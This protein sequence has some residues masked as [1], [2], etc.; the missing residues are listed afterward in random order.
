MH[1]V[2]NARPTRDYIECFVSAGNHLQGVLR[3]C[4]IVYRWLKAEPPLGPCLEHLSFILMIMSGS[5]IETVE[6]LG[7]QRPLGG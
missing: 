3:Q 4:G 6:L 2:E 7:D 5:N 1:E